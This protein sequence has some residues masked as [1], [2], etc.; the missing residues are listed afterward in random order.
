MTVEGISG[1]SWCGG[2]RS[3]CSLCV[4]LG[5]SLVGPWRERTCRIPGGREGG[6]EGACILLCHIQI[7]YLG[8]HIDNLQ[9]SLNTEARNKYIPRYTAG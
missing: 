6:R 3:V 2:S 7:S 1:C 8:N 5:A 4:C 9:L